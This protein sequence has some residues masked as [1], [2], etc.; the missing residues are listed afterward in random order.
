MS[1]QLAETQQDLDA[2]QLDLDDKKKLL[3]THK[4]TIRLS[5][6]LHCTGSELR[7]DRCVFL[8]RRR[9]DELRSVTQERQELEREL[10]ERN[11]QLQQRVAQVRMCHLMTSRH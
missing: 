9:E 4:K 1:N 5:P 10:E 11:F 3:E 2:N 6:P 7:C 8:R